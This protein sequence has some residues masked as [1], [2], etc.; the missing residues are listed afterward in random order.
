[1][2]N[3]ADKTT[4]DRAMPG[5]LVVASGTPL[6]IGL[7]Q[8]HCGLYKPDVTESAQMGGGIRLLM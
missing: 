3:R 6:G 7:E 2:A 8:R 5:N 4:T 1:L